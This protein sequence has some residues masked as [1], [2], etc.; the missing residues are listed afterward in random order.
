MKSSGNTI[1]ITGGATGIGL[2][3]AKLFAAQDNTVI[4]CGRRNNRLEEAGAMIPGLHTIVCDVTLE[5]EREN[6][7]QWVV[8]NFPSVNILINNAGIQHNYDL[9]KKIDISHVSIEVETNFIAPVH[10]S[11]LFSEHLKSLPEAAIINITSGLAFTPLAF[12]SVYCATKAALHSFSLSLRHQLAGTTIKVFEILPP[13]VD[14][15]L[16]G[17]ARDRR[18]D[19]NRGMNAD[20]FAIKALEAI[21]R[22]EYEAAIGTA[23][24]LRSKREEAFRFLNH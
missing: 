11:N 1:V 17:G 20:D 15:E 13:M 5:A 19:H 12:M 3:M 23:E 22:D 2:A 9:K 16:D 18:D 4:I 6:L 24:N 8:T 14:T 7:Y 10:L 21:H